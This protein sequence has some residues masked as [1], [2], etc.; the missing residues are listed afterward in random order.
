MLRKRGKNAPINLN[1]TVTEQLI[2]S[3]HARNL[4]QAR[5]RSATKIALR[6]ASMRSTEIHT[7]FL[8]ISLLYV[9]APYFPNS[10]SI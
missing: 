10:T 7:L 2:G 6:N 3:K 5:L 4:R 1:F 8:K 9:C